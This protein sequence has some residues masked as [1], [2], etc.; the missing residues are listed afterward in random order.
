MKKLFKGLLSLVIF[1]EF[2]F[3]QGVKESFALENY[4]T[5]TF[6]P[7]V[8]EKYIKVL[9]LMTGTK[10]INKIS[11]NIYNLKMLDEK[12]TQAVKQYS[13]LLLM[14]PE[15]INVSTPQN[16]ISVREFSFLSKVKAG[17]EIPGV[18][19]VRFQKNSKITDI[20]KM[21]KKYNTTSEIISGSL[22][23][24]KIKLPASLNVEKAIKLF[25]QEKIVLY[26]EAD[27]VMT[28]QKN[29]NDV[30]SGEFSS[31]KPQINL[32]D[33]SVTFKPGS[34]EIAVNL[35]NLVYDANLIEQKSSNSYLYKLAENTNPEITL[36]ALKLCPYIMNIKLSQRNN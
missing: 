8:T 23:L 12:N 21:D 1:I 31:M 29:K 18:I 36:N 30:P 22:N 2:S 17:Q 7:N 11:D 32:P 20:K 24:Y 35:F 26:A 16:K 9:N 15:V 10:I 19:L 6:K 14:I 28:I 34:E 4:L 5:V 27:R 25:S 33:L 13:H 3:F